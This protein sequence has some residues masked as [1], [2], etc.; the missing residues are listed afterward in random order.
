LLSIVAFPVAAVTL[1]VIGC[2]AL[3][4]V[5]E[6][7]IANRYSLLIMALAPLHHATTADGVTAWLLVAGSALAAAATMF[8]LGFVLWRLGGLGG[9]DV[10][11]LCAAVFFVG[12]DGV[13]VLL[14]ATVLAGGAL[15][16][17]YVIVPRLLPA[18]WAL[19]AGPDRPSATGAGVSIPYGVAI[20][21]G[22]AAAIVPTLPTVTG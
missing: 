14:G 5:R 15:A 19:L 8:L 12:A 9:G 4:D 21:L 7:L 17:V 3:Q 2:A 1:A 16:L 18:A 10:K 13:A 11:L 6:R 22:L 20:A